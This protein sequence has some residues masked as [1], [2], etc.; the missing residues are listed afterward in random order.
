[1]VTMQEIA[2]RAGVTRATVSN[3]LNGRFAAERSDAAER[4]RR[5]REIAAQ[6]GY[7]PSTLARAQRTRRTGCIGMLSAHYPTY[8]VHFG[9]FDRALV[10]ALH[11]RGLLLVTDLLARPGETGDDADEPPLPRL[12][13]ESLADGFLINYGFAIPDHVQR[14]ID[15]HDLAAVWINADRPTDAVRPNDRDAAAKTVAF[16]RDRGHRRIAYSDEIQTYRARGVEAHYSVA[17][18]RAGYEAAMRE[19]GLEPAFVG[20]D[21]AKIAEAAAEPDRHRRHAERCLLECRAIGATALIHNGSMT[22]VML[23][24]A[25][26]GVAIPDELSVIHFENSSGPYVYDAARIVVPF[27]E[28]ARRAVAMLCDRI[29]GAPRPAP[30][31]LVAYGPHDGPTVRRRPMP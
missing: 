26:A 18:R 30:T 7:R 21:G 3:V 28:V 24:A 20:R 14:M 5:I 25:A 22:P 31:R 9:G 27:P 2:E 19:A 4:A 6:M 10:E 15:R 1:M 17:E 13:A 16:L 11:E 12:V 23:A 29:D 8:S